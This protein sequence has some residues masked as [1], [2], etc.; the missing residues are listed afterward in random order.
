VNSRTF[1]LYPDRRSELTS[2]A[3]AL[4]TR[5]YNS[6]HE[7]EVNIVIVSRLDLPAATKWQVAKLRITGIL[8]GIL[9]RTQAES[10]QAQSKLDHL[11]S[12]KN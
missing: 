11:R 12:T 4:H 10:N 5:I 1:T 6:A 3:G 7:G 8:W 2:E 9:L